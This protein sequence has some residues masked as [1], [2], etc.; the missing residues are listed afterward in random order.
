M[1]KHIVSKISIAQGARTVSMSNDTNVTGSQTYFPQEEIANLYLVSVY[2]MNIE[3]RLAFIVRA[4]SPVS[5]KSMVLQQ[6]EQNGYAIESRARSNIL[7]VENVGD[8]ARVD[9]LLV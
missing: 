8:M 2:E 7:I 1:E 3:K 5:A 4:K 9:H 6:C